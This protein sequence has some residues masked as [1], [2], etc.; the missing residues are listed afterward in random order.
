MTLLLIIAQWIVSLIAIWC[1]GYVFYVAVKE[2]L[3]MGILGI[4]IM[5][6]SL[7][8]FMFMYWKKYPI[9][10]VLILFLVCLGVAA[11][12]Q[13]IRLGYWDWPD[14]DSRPVAMVEKN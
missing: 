3:V 10:N 13:R 7:P 2:N 8:I 9:R 1:I 6:I 4:L 14:V 5:P 11:G 12:L